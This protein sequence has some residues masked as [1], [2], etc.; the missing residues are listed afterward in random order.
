MKKK[1]GIVAAFIVLLVAATGCEGLKIRMLMNEGHRK[2]KAHEYNAAIES[3]KKILVLEPDDW[4]ANYYIA[5]SHLALYHPG[6]THA[7]DIAAAEGSIQHLEKLLKMNPPSEEKAA[8]VRKYYISLLIAADKSD[9][10]IEYL[11][12]EL[13]KNPGDTTNLSQIAQL[14]AKKGDFPNALKYFEKVAQ[15]KNAK[16]DWYTVGVVCWERSFRGKDVNDT[17]RSELAKKGLEAIEKALKLDPEYVDAILYKNLLF[18]EQA[19]VLG[20]AGN[21]EEAYR[22]TMQAQSLLEK[23]MVL[24]KKQ[25]EAAKKA[26]SA[27]GPEAGK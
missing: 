13:R 19:K 22:L 20:N 11:E 9:K 3:Y 12:N 24:R 8:L 7:K 14:Y 6:S 1:L 26:G 18:R 5:V 4:D 25:A 23:A 2:Y 21:A 16:E 10:A 27:P 15:T 17:E